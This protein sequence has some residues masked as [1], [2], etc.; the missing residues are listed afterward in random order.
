MQATMIGLDIAK[1]VFHVHGEE[2]NGKVVM[3]KRLS[4]GQLEAYFKKLP[5]SVVGIE[6][7]GTAH[8]WG[9][10]LQAL[11]HEVRLIP[12]GY[13]KPFV[14]RNKTDA[15]DAAA[16]CVAMQRPN[17]RCVPIKSVAQQSARALERARDLLVKQRT[18]LMNCVRS[19]LAEMGVIAAQG[20]CGFT[21]LTGR[22]K[23]DADPA[24][25]A[26]LRPV[27]RPLL[28]QIDNL[29]DSVQG[30]ED[31]IMA[32]A[33]SHPV[34][35]R[36]CS[37]PGIGGITAHAIVSAVGDGSQFRSARDF[38]AWCGLTPRE[39]SSGGKQRLEGIS[40]QGDNR[41]RKLLALG[42]ST[43]M[44][45]ARAH[46]ER[47]TAW[48]RGILA[49]RPVKVAVLAQAARNARIAWALLRSG[50]TYRRPVSATA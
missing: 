2:P 43:L 10:R 47:A 44:R 7:C 1:S 16:I 31:K 45:H 21:V 32:A 12:A 20:T 17:M 19:L 26:S 34:M 14:Q 30:L 13:V 3:Q 25:P 24:I 39:H 42:A 50:E 38:A 28:Q 15:R 48:Q 46:G 27:L 18:Q 5:A 6:A 37:I 36:L 35:Q 8:D 23:D 49:R 41:L 33:R 22:V 40:R 29:K 4:R 9:R 11:G